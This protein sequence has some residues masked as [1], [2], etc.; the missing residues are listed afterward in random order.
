MGIQ[1]FHTV[2]DIWFLIF[3]VISIVC[4]VLAVLSV[5]RMNRGFILSY[6]LEAVTV[7]VN[8][9]FMYITD[10]DYVDYGNNKFSGLSAL[11]DWLGFCMLILITLIPLIVTVICNI[12]Y[13][14][15]K[16]TNSSN[17]LERRTV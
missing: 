2:R 8:L 6:V 15:K 16:K 12:R 5:K 11:G 13:L 7:L 14:I 4:I 3:F 17:G 9:S 1:Q 10:R